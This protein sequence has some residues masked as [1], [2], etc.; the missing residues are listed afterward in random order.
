[1]ITKLRHA[2]GDNTPEIVIIVGYGEARTAS[3]ATDAVRKLTG[4]TL[5]SH[6]P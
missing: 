1:M 3:T 6:N 5:I 4:I 2:G